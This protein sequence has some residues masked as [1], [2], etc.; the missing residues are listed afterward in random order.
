MGASHSERTPAGE[1]GPLGFEHVQV[2]ALA[3]SK[4]HPGQTGGLAIRRRLLQA[5][6][7]RAACGAI[8]LEGIV[9]FLQCA[10]HGLVVGDQGLLRAC[11]AGGDPRAHAPGVE[12]RPAQDRAEHTGQCARAAHRIEAACNEAD[13]ALHLNL[14]V[15][16]S[17]LH[18]DAGGRRGEPALGRRNVG[19]P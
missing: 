10:Q 13:R 7:Q 12:H 3:G 11:L 9:G 14:G 18:P 4:P 8:G 16:R 1:V 5:Q 17:R 2:E 15:E 19:A 6:A